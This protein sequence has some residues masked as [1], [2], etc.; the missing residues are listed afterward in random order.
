M[1]L[2]R[3]INVQKFS[4][5]LHRFDN[6]VRSPDLPLSEQGPWLLVIYGAPARRRL[7]YEDDQ[8]R[9]VDWITICLM[10]IRDSWI[11]VLEEMD[12]QAFLKVSY[13]RE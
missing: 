12:K 8:V 2:T 9:L 7:Q 11:S 3:S 5:S 4:M 1:N 6:R 13:E 10:M